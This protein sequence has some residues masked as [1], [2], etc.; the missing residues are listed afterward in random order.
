MRQWGWGGK[1]TSSPSSSSNKNNNNKKKLD[2]KS[3]TLKSHV[4]GYD[5]KPEKHNTKK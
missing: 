4:K 3:T 5:K 2:N 1:G